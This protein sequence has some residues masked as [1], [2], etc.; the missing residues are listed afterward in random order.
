MSL[1]GKVKWF[2]EKKGFG[3]IER[4]DG[5]KDVFVHISA[6]QAAGLDYLDEGSS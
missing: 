2:N 1:K 4:E 3:F 5:K 6:V